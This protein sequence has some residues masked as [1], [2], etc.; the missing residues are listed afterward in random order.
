MESMS[1]TREIKEGALRDSLE[2][3]PKAA[4]PISNTCGEPR[5]ERYYHAF[6]HPSISHVI[7]PVPLPTDDNAAANNIF[8]SGWHQLRW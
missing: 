1:V 7:K 6:S 4:S 5:R 2:A 3:H 8:G